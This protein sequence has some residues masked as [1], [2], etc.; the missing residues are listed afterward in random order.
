MKFPNLRFQRQREYPTVHFSFSRYIARDGSTNPGFPKSGVWFKR[1]LGACK[2]TMKKIYRNLRRTAWKFI[3]FLVIIVWPLLS[4]NFSKV[5]IYLSVNCCIW[6]LYSTA[7]SVKR[8]QPPLCCRKCIFCFL[9]PLS[10]LQIIFPNELETD[11][12]MNVFSHYCPTLSFFSVEKLIKKTWLFL[13]W[14]FVEEYF[15]S[16]Q[17]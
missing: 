17:K 13:Y 4:A 9:P 1:L 7:T 12:A 16:R 3:F 6:Y 14:L 15:C 10:G 8:P 11:D 2:R 5:P